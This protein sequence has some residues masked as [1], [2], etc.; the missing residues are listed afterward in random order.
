MRPEVLSQINSDKRLA[1]WT[2]W[3]WNHIGPEIH[4]LHVNREMWLGTQQI[5]AANP[6][7]PRSYW[8][9]F[10][11]D[12]YG[13]MLAV[14][15]RRQ[16]EAKDGVITLGR[17]VLEISNTPTHLSRDYY[18][19]RYG[20]DDTR[21]PW[22]RQHWAE[23]FAGDVGDHL[24]PK[25]PVADLERMTN[26]VARVKAVADRH[27]AHRDRRAVPAD[28]VAALGE[29]HDAIDVIGSIYRR[30]M[31][32]MTGVENAVLLPPFDHDWQAVFRQPWIDPSA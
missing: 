27:L 4:S 16:V 11:S 26:A 29:A 22:A 1:K 6:T 18:L 28:S 32:L 20:T 12:T 24:D 19:T 3:L 7:L 13:T 23:E 17:L 15:L 21:L 31:C 9:Q 8:W 14:A 25:I 10:M 5:I 30:Y 2:G